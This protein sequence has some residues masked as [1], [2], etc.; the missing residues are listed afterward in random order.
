MHIHTYRCTYKYD[1]TSND[2][3][4]HTFNTYIHTF[5]V[6]KGIETANLTSSD[7]IVQDNVLMHSLRRED[8]ELAAANQVLVYIV[9]TYIGYKFY[10]HTFL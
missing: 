2:Y 9:H 8:G 6:K 10:I 7:T 4:I 3:D 1:S 5:A